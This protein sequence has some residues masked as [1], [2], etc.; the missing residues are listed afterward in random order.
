[1]ADTETDAYSAFRDRVD[2]SRVLA[3]EVL[4]SNFLNLPS[5]EGPS[6]PLILVDDIS[7]GVPKRV[8]VRAF[9]TARRN[10]YGFLDV[11]RSV[12]DDVDDAL[13]STFV[14]LLFDP[15]HL[16]A[17]NL[18]KRILLEGQKDTADDSKGSL[19]LQAA[20]RE[21]IAIETLLTSPLHRHTKSPTLWYHRRWVLRHFLTYLRWGTH[22][23]F[24][25]KG[26]W[27]QIYRP[28]LLIVMKA[29]EHHPRNY[30]AW[31]HA[32]WLVD[33]LRADADGAALPSSLADSMELVQEW[34]LKHQSD[35]SGW[36]FLLYLYIQA[37]KD[38]EIRNLAFFNAEK[39]LCFALDFNWD[40]ESIWVFLR[41]V[42]ASP[43]LLPERQRLALTKR[44]RGKIEETEKVEVEVENGYTPSVRFM[45]SALV[46][47]D[48]Y[49]GGVN[50]VGH[51]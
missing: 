43:S 14:V 19:M 46:W 10:L 44:I 7:I 12:A 20:K 35:I 36:S 5:V 40:F 42:I 30:Y 48:M 24:D 26:L 32:R 50:T 21:L 45:R 2:L 27:Q 11:S 4:P 9:I 17:A 39:V 3:I 15:E 29:G 1:M 28:E 6:S 33:N 13:L 23:S 22:E 41:T 37:S 51:H 34:C 47:I 18:R 31:S 8:L 38:T 25:P 16:A 49:G